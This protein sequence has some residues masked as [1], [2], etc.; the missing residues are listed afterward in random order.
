MAVEETDIWLTKWHDEPIKICDHILTKD[1][2]ID[3]KMFYHYLLQFGMYRPSSNSKKLVMSLKKNKTWEKVNELLEKYKKS[4]GGPTIPIYI[5]PIGSGNL[6]SPKGNKSGVSFEDKLFLFLSDLEDEK[7]LE[8][9]FIHEYH[10]ICRLNGIKKSMGEYT[11]LDSIV[12][13]GLAEDTVHSILGF[14][15]VA[16]WNKKLTNEQFQTYWS[17]YLKDNLDVKKDTKQ[18]DQLLYGKGLLPNMLGYSCGYHLVRKYTEQ[19]SYST[20][21]SFRISSENFVKNLN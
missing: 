9:L 12:L 8:A 6:V 21:E 5:F 10:H 15:Y 11:L 1:K 17:K 14:K 20:K 7:E 2:N 18:H 13:E 16:S 3:G 4:W 19:K